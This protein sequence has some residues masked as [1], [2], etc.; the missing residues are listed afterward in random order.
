MMPVTRFGTTAARSRALLF[1]AAVAITVVSTSAAAL[2][3]PTKQHAVILR[4]PSAAR[5]ESSPGFVRFTTPAAWA[6][7]S[8][9]DPAISRVSAQFGVKLASG[10]VAGAVASAAAT[11][12][13]SSAA[14]QLRSEL[15]AASQPGIPRPGPVRTLAA[16]R[17]QHG[18]GA[19]RLVSPTNPDA[20]AFYGG[21]LISGGRHHWAGLTVAISV[22]RAC[23]TE[24]FQRS[25]QPHALERLLR[26]I[27]LQRAH[28]G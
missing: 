28:G 9:P 21:A 2:G 7:R 12:S 20:E 4:L 8:I 11:I 22:S 15:P 14:V 6:R 13:R 17:T 5:N 18:N 27:T 24:L 26:T 1:S 19:W 3:P 25:G 23:R 16:G 10:C